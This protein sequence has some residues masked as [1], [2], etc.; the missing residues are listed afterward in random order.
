MNTQTNALSWSDRF[1]L[2]DKYKPSDEVICEKLDVSQDELDT[3]RDLRRAG[4]FKAKV[5]INVGN[6]AKMLS[7]STK[8]VTVKTENATSHAKP[9]T[10]TKAK[11]PVASTPT[12]AT[13]PVRELKKRGRKG[14]KIANAFVAVP[15]EAVSAESFIAEHNVS[16]A[17][18]RQA[19]RFDKSGLNGS[20]CV[21][22]DKV[23]KTLMVWRA[24]PESK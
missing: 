12:T 13:K 8:P 3:A 15:R 1:A 9:V 4:N 17:V 18:L 7:G 20:V 16:L 2:I 23:T 11:T 21:K 14:S 22:Q 6:Y 10:K 5:E 24:V 19:R